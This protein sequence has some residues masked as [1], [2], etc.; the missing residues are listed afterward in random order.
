MTVYVITG[1]DYDSDFHKG[2]LIGV[3]RKEP[4]ADLIAL[5][6]SKNCNVDIGHPYNISNYPWGKILECKNGII[7]C[8]I[9]RTNLL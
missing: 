9:E 7:T 6:Y 4:D 8:T 1:Y 2:T 3:Y 5:Q